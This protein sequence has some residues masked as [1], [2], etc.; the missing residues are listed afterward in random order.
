M[1]P[2]MRTRSATKTFWRM[3]MPSAAGWSVRRVGL[4]PIGK[5][6]LIVIHDPGAA[7][8]FDVHFERMWEAAQPMD[9]FEPAIRALE[10]R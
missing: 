8:K 4:A 1:P 3:P 7:A 10:P 9:E 2:L 5:R 6:D